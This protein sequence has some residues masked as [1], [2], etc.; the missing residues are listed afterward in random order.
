MVIECEGWRGRQVRHGGSLAL[1]L[2]PTP[3]RSGDEALGRGKTSQSR[4]QLWESCR[5]G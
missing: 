3:K 1:M 5:L 4:Q 2:H